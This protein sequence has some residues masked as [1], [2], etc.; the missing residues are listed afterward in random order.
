MEAARVSQ[1]ATLQLLDALIV[2]D[3]LRAGLADSATHK[4]AGVGAGTACQVLVDR[5]AQF[6]EEGGD[7]LG[8]RVVVTL[9]LAQLAAAARMDTVTVGSEVFTLDRCIAR[10]ESMAQ[11]VVVNA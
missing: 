10:D 3:L 4:P 7:V 11:W 1:T 5:N 9:F 8:R 6:F 2:E